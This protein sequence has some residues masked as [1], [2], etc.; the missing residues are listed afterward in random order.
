MR[1]WGPVLLRSP[2]LPCDLGLYRSTQVHYS[3]CGTISAQRHI[4]AQLAGTKARRHVR[5]SQEDA[6]KG[7]HPPHKFAPMLLLPRGSIRIQ[8]KHMRDMIGNAIVPQQHPCVGVAHCATRPARE[9]RRRNAYMR[10][11]PPR[12][13]TPMLVLATTSITPRGTNSCHLPA[14]R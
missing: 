11:R 5:A 10:P 1:T 7:S 3:R 2:E 8:Y 12:T 6:H 9:A 14:Q 4:S 13:R